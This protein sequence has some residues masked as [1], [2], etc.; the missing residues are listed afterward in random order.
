MKMNLIN[1]KPQ[2]LQTFITIKHSKTHIGT[3][4]ENQRIQI[5][6]QKTNFF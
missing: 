4:L 1:S 5:K 3:T 2:Q 6:T